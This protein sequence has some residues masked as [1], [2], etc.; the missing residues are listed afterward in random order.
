MDLAHTPNAN[1]YYI[2]T[3]SPWPIVAALAFFAKQNK[4]AQPTAPGEAV[5]AAALAK[6][7]EANASPAIAT[8]RP[9]ALRRLT[10]SALCSGSTSAST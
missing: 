9:S 6:P 2:P 5:G 8:T 4:Q 10:T 7:S 3:G 1:K